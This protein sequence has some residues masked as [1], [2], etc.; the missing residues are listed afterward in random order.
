[1]TE[2]SYGWGVVKSLAIRIPRTGP[3]SI[4]GFFSATQGFQREKSARVLAASCR[5]KKPIASS[6]T[7]G[8][9]REISDKPP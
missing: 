6:D 8:P 7:Y 1:M 4:Q 3:T 5:P 2:C 9:Q